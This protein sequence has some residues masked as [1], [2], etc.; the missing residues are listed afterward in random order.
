MCLYIIVLVVPEMLAPGQIL[1]FYWTVEFE[2]IVLRYHLYFNIFIY[3]LG[4]K[5][6]FFF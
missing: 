3:I 6:T 5:K 2:V 4:G 1:V